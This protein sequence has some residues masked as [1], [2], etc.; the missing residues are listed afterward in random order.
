MIQKHRFKRLPKQYSNILT[1]VLRRSRTVS[2]HGTLRTFQGVQSNKRQQHKHKTH[3]F[4]G[5]H[6]HSPPGPTSH[7]KLQKSLYENAALRKM[8]NFEVCFSNHIIARSGPRERSAGRGARCKS[9][10]LLG[11]Q[12]ACNLIARLRRRSERIFRRW[13]SP[14]FSHSSAG[15]QNGRGDF[16]RFMLVWM[17]SIFDGSR[18]AWWIMTI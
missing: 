4:R 1:V 15:I 18:I 14:F 16:T 11:S 13:C 10:P 3:N 5:P 8:K 9:R 12:P 6:L 17:D 2:T 7:Q